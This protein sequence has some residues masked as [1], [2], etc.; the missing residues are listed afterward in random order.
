MT[1]FSL[2]TKH[3]LGQA[4]GVEGLPRGGEPLVSVM[5]G[6][7]LRLSEALP[8]TCHSQVSTFEDIHGYKNRELSFGALLAEGGD[9]WLELA[10]R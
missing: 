6:R 1:S 9:G 4:N 3:S 7:W 2:P 8:P 10:R 5:G